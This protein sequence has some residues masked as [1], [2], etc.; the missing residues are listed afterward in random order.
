MCY[1]VLIAIGIFVLYKA[2]PLIMMYLGLFGWGM[3]DSG[4]KR[5]RSKENIVAKI[6]KE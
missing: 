5:R 2:A 4:K 6:D 3:I 1:L